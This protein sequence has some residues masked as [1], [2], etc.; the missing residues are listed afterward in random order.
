M[1]TNEVIANLALERMGLEKGRYDVVNPN[2]HVNRSQ[3]T[4]DAYP[5]GLHIAVFAVVE[6]LKAEVEALARAFEQK[7]SEFADVLKMG[8]TQLQDAVPMTLGQEFK[9]YAD[10]MREEIRQLALAAELLL[11]VN[12]GATAIGTGLNTPDGYSQCAVSK[13]AEVTGLPLVLAENLIQATS[14]TGAYVSMHA[15]TKRVAVKLSKICND[16]RLLSSGPRAGLHEI[17]LPELQAGSSIMPAKVNPVLPEVVNQVCFKVIGNDVT[18]GMAAEA[19]QLQLNVME[20]VIAQCL[21]ESVALLTNACASLRVRCVDG[22]TA[23]PKVC[24][25]Y[26][27]NSIGIVTF[28]TPII[29]H[30]NGDLVGR[31]CARS[32]K[33]V[34]AVVLE[35][36][37][38]SE[39][40]LDENFSPE[41]L[42]R[43]LYR[44][45]VY[46]AQ[47]VSAPIEGDPR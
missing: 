18:V 36:G 38:L 14:D 10:L 43:P 13:L 11:E 4:N 7:S 34:R 20:P 5:T 41:N 33:D 35:M 47:E 19:G 25:A 44:G 6:E 9:V 45:K 30:H 1:N 29:G 28:L 24:H 37:L 27:M 16:L 31:E 3:S 22:I 46:A 8:R 23:N 32:G 39:A 17:N 26:V 42:V 2:D 12:L 40:D 15:A 21:F